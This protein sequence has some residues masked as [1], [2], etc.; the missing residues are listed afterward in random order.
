[1]VSWF[2]TIS[3]I[4]GR[5]PCFHVVF[6]DLVGW[7]RKISESFGRFPC[8]PFVFFP[9]W[10]AVLRLLKVDFNVVPLFSSW[11]TVF[12]VDFHVIPLFSQVGQRFSVASHVSPL[13][14]EGAITKQLELMRATYSHEF[15]ERAAPV[16]TK[17][18]CAGLGS[19]ANLSLTSDWR[20]P[21]FGRLAECPPAAR[22]RTRRARP[23]ILLSNPHRQHQTRHQCDRNGEY[24][25]GSS[26]NTIA[27]NAPRRQSMGQTIFAE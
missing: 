25:L 2:R 16:Q 21:C 8:Y 24:D 1:M 19:R 12:H 10:S 6:F 14:S 3:E 17:P 26:S 22:G 20:D 23:G 7:F 18:R 11:S 9:S 5:F 13:S 27:C 15:V 4:F